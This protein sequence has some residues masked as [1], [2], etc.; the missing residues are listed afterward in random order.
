MD[1]SSSFSYAGTEATQNK[2]GLIPGRRIFRLISATPQPTQRRDLALTLTCRRSWSGRP[3]RLP[4]HVDKPPCSPRAVD[5]GPNRAF[6]LSPPLP[7]SFF[8]NRGFG[9]EWLGNLPKF[10][11]TAHEAKPASIAQWQSTSLVSCWSRVRLPVEAFETLIR[12]AVPCNPL[13]E[14]QMCWCWFREVTSP[15]QTGR[16]VRNWHGPPLSKAVTTCRPAPVGRRI[17]RH[18]QNTRK[19]LWSIWG[20]NP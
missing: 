5:F 7:F 19:M 16:I 20:S 8:S 18:G 2:A 6:L 14:P 10:A 9:H 11:T 15:Q 4:V 3:A 12:G 1:S 17:L 13:A